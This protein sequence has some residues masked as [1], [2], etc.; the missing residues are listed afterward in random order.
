MGTIDALLDVIGLLWNRWCNRGWRGWRK[1]WSGQ[2]YAD[3]DAIA[4]VAALTTLDGNQVF[5]IRL[6]LEAWRV[7]SS[8]PQM[9]H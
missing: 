9:F 5:L 8:F 2:P 3:R 1:R 7:T 4:K 6:G